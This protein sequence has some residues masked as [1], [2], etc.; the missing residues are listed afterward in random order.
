[1]APVICERNAALVEK[2]RLTYEVSFNASGTVRL[3]Q[4]VFFWRKFT[5]EMNSKDAT[6]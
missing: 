5:F 4:R 1:M 6:F 3:F 2:T